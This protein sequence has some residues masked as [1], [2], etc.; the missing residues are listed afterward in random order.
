MA[1]GQSVFHGFGITT[2]KALLAFPWYSVDSS[3]WGQG[4]RFG[5]VPLFD[6]S[7][8]EFIKLRLG[9]R[10]DWFK[11]AGLVRS[12]GF[13]PADFADRARNDRAKICGI[14]ALAYM[15]AEAWLRR[16]HGEISM[17]RRDAPPGL[18]VY[19]ADGSS[20]NLGDADKG[21]KLYLADAQKDLDIG[22]GWL[23]I[24]ST[25]QEHP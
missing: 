14:S 3:S 7:R 15:K 2:W 25:R 24:Q 10:K 21:L 4:F 13:D 12:Y 17:P 8:G 20:G 22:R 16:Y 6:S 18:R 5:H 19:I 11:H 9:D 23:A 1:K